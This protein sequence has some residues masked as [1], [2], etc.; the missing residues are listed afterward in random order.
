MPRSLTV[1]LMLVAGALTAADPVA[2][3]DRS[4]DHAALR[5]LLARVTTAIGSGEVQRLQECLATPFSITFADQR[6]FTTIEA[7]RAYDADLRQSRQLARV[8]VSPAADELTTFLSADTGCCTGTSTDR[9]TMTD[10][11]VTTLTSRWTATVVRQAGGW[12]I[13]AVHAGIDPFDNP[14]LTRTRAFALWSTVG[15][16]AIALI[17]GLLVGRAMARRRAA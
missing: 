16:A 11:S 10:G 8:E 7:V 9:F 17:V 3:D 15:G 6:R 14:I 5:D 4:A 12:R 1:M 13:A 2:G